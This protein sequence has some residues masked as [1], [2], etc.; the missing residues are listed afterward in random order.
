MVVGKVS[1]TAVE[2]KDRASGERENVAVDDSCPTWSG[3]CVADGVDAVI[4]D[5]G[6]TLTPWKSIDPA[7]EWATLARAAAGT[8]RPPWRCWRR[9]TR[10]GALP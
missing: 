3:S 4:F 10:L 7:E 6:G 2:V 5:W 9:P 1:P 8:R